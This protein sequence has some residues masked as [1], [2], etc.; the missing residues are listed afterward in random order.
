VGQ[1][2]PA[3]DPAAPA[4]GDSGVFAALG[5]EQR[6]A[7]TPPHSTVQ[8]LPAVTPEGEQHPSD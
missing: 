5:S 7:S 2:A 3:A 8:F 6:D 1:G 4:T